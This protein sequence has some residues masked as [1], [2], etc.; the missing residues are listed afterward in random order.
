MIKVLR[1][2]GVKRFIGVGDFNT[3]PCEI[4]GLREIYCHDLF[5]QHNPDDNKTYI[6]KIFTNLANVRV[7]ALSPIEKRLENC[8][9]KAY[10]VSIGPLQVNS[11]M[12]LKQRSPHYI[13]DKFG[14]L[15]YRCKF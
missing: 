5:H 12:G 1:K 7:E 8:G 3:N 11:H 13:A 9:H 6:D 10:L 14:I 2:R 15:I 4:D